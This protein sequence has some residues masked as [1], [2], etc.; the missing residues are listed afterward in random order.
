MLPA[1]N[2]YGKH[3]SPAAV[4]SRSRSDAGAAHRRTASRSL[5][6][7]FVDV[8][9]GVLEIE[10]ARGHALEPEVVLGANVFAD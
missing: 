3:G 2:G 6:A 5:E 8:A 9:S 10:A 7:D 1:P 4:L